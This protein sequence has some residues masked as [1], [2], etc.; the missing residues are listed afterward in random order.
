[1]IGFSIVFIAAVAIGTAVGAPGMPF[2]V[3]AGALFG[4]LFGSIISWIGAISARRAGYWV[5]RT[6]GHKVVVNW[7]R[8]FKRASGAEDDASISR[9]AASATHSRSYHRDP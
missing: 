6:I 9:H 1:M 2:V 5:A 8:R 4:T 3:T 7:L